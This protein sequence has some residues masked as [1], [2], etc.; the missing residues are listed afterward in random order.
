MNLIAYLK[1]IGES[2][3]LGTTPKKWIAYL[4]GAT[5]EYE[6]EQQG[7]RQPGDTALEAINILTNI[8]RGKH[9][10]YWKHH[11]T[12]TYSFQFP[13]DLEQTTIETFNNQG[14]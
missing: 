6:G 1:K 2:L 13:D 14:E 12:P 3:Q 4:P 9:V 10:E 11:S 8:V 7:W 5:F